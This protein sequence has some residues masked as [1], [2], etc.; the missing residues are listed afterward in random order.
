[1]SLSEK[2]RQ[3][4]LDNENRNLLAAAGAVLIPELDKVL[5]DFY[6]RARADEKSAAFFS[7]EKQIESARAAQKKHW[8]K[9]L[10]GEFDEVYEASTERIGRTH[11]RINLPLDV[12]MS[13]YSCASAQLLQ[14]LTRKLGRKWFGRGRN[15]ADMIA[16][17]S[18]AF[19]LDVERVTTVTFAVWGEEQTKA[20]EHINIAIEAMANGDLTHAIPSPQES[21]YPASYDAVRRRMN[22]AFENLGGMF[23]DINLSMLTLVEL[24]EEVDNSARELSHRTSNQAASLEE[25]AAAMEELTNSVAEASRSTTD[26]AKVAE[27]SRYDVDRSSE[28][29]QN[30]AMAMGRIK[31]SAEKISQITTLID[32]IAFQTNLLALNAGVEAARAG[33]AGLGFAVVA[34]EVRTLASHSSS[35]AKDIRDLISASVAEISEGAELVETARSNLEL[36]TESFQ[37]VSDLSKQISSAGEEQTK[38]LSEVN[39]SVSQMDTITQKNAA[40]VEAT[41]NSMSEI[42]Q[43]AVEIMRLLRVLKMNDR[44]EFDRR[45]GLPTKTGPANASAAA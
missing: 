29:V 1:M 33:Q 39:I 24:V 19:A 36:L 12:Y 34:G 21:D 43:S 16:V 32:D 42:K 18:R 11:A 13:A 6:R 17:V 7:S 5:D 3:F 14:I 22:G 23:A 4:D 41:T 30:A 38:G 20:F 10:G 26:A 40:M 45:T 44:R 31:K 27:A 9:L 25:T 2:L 28:V 8:L 35:A 15:L 37:K